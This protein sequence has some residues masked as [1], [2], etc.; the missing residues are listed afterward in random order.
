MVTFDRVTASGVTS[1]AETDTCVDLPYG[2]LSPDS[3]CYDISTDAGATWVADRVLTATGTGPGELIN[4]NITV[5]E[6]C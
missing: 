1:L 3:S 6:G 4:G 2:L 5:R